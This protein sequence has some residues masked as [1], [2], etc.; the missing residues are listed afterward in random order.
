MVEHYEI[1]VI[2]AG[3]AGASIAA[4]LAP[5]ARVVLCEAEDYPGYHTTGRSAAFYEEC[6]GGPDVVPLTLASGDYLRDGGFLTPRGG[7]YVARAGQAEAVDKFLETFR[8]AG[9]TI[10]RL[11]RAGLEALLPGV[12]AG[13]DHALS[14]PNCADI[15][16][17]GLHQHYLARAKAGGVDLRTR[18]RLEAAQRDG[19][20]WLLDFG[21]AGALRADLVVNAAGA[22]ADP[23]AQ[24]CGAQPLGIQPLRRTVAQLRVDPAPPAD[25]PLTLDIAG[26]FYFRPDNRRLWLSPH[27]ETPSEPCDAAPEE[28]D[29]ALAIDRFEQ[30][31]DWKI[32]AVERKWAGLRSFSPDRLPVY[33]CDPQVEGFFWFAGQGGYGI[34]T[35]P[36]A[37]RYGA[38]LLLGL[39]RDAMTER[40]DGNL[41]EPARFTPLTV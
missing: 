31:V 7:L 8:D 34:Q 6:Y 18:H 20:G 26:D 37:A 19:P 27:D 21:A 39:P 41:Y 14:Q 1:A 4:E 12:R 10:D 15:D 11:D 24:L 33:G 2:G 17:A 35:A 36:A 23:V 32:E 16:V 5:H 28:Y 22:W 38:Q 29:V 25:L 13:W 9:V 40:L 3:M 30:V